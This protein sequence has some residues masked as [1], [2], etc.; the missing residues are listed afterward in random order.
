MAEERRSRNLALLH[1]LSQS[2][3]LQTGGRGN[4]CLK[5]GSPCCNGSCQE[6]F[7]KMNSLNLMCCRVIQALLQ[8]MKKFPS[9]SK[10]PLLPG[11][12]LGFMVPDG[13]E[14]GWVWIQLTKMTDRNTVLC[15]QLFSWAGKGMHWMIRPVVICYLNMLSQIYVCNE[16][17]GR[18][19]N[20]I[21][22][23]DYKKNSVQPLQCDS[24]TGNNKRMS[25]F[26]LPINTSHSGQ[27]FS[28]ALNQNVTI[29]QKEGGW[30]EDWTAGVWGNG[31]MLW[32]WSL[33]RSPELF[34]LL[35]HWLVCR[36]F[37]L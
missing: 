20:K 26:L 19:C 15:C 14:N 11:Q 3:S 30:Q 1:L 2:R 23:R 4:L 17:R 5:E 36:T 32:N 37:Y 25:H 8:L 18:D 13:T 34:L 21:H 33:S 12:A 35:Q 29:S 7:W 24:P 22:G 6:R 28:L 16:I 31:W 9:A 10:M 27:I